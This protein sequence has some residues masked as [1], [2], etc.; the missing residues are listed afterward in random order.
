MT[1]ALSMHNLLLDCY[2]SELCAWTSLHQ[3]PGNAN[4]MMADV[5]AVEMAS[6]RTST[7]LCRCNHGKS[8][9]AKR[10]AA[11]NQRVEVIHH[12]PRGGAFRA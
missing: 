10:V 2:T 6:L 12:H 9:V 4:L 11:E 3:I 8:T 5:A 1:T 7:S